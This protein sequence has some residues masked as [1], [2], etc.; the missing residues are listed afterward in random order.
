MH[1]YFR[2]CNCNFMWHEH[3]NSFSP[4]CPECQST[5]VDAEIGVMNPQDWFSE[6]TKIQSA[7]LNIDDICITGHT[8][9]PKILDKLGHN[10][11]D[12]EVKRLN[13]NINFWYGV[14]W[15]G[16][17]LVIFGA[18]ARAIFS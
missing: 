18:T 15:F 11:H 17:G 10:H 14:M 6:P 13:R 8:G 2:C 3:G 9:T 16:L 12:E 4:K 5:R 7:P 1:G